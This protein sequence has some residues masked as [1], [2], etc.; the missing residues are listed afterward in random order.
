MRRCVRMGVVSRVTRVCSFSAS[1]RR[2]VALHTVMCS[3]RSRAARKAEGRSVAAYARSPVLLEA[4]PAWQ[5]EGTGF[6]G[7]A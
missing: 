5:R 4:V 1:V 3:S 6:G 7:I 2:V